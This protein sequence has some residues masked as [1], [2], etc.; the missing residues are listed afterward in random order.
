MYQ[1]ACA[2]EATFIKNSTLQLLAKY[3]RNLKSPHIWKQLS[4]CCTEHKEFITTCLIAL[5]NTDLLG[6]ERIITEGIY[7]T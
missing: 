3:Q 6:Y 4:V 5:K 7:R 2:D 1:I